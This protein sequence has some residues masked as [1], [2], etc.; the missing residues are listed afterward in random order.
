VL[1]RDGKPGFAEV[2][3]SGW[4]PPAGRS[5]ALGGTGKGVAR[6]KG[7]KGGAAPAKRGAAP[8]KS[9]AGA[10]KLSKQRELLAKRFAEMQYDLGGIAYEM[11]IRDKFRT[12]VLKDR[13]AKLRELD[14]QL[15]Q[16]DG[17][18]RLGATGVAGSCPNCDALQAKGAKFCWQCGFNL[19]AKRPAKPKTTTSSAK[20]AARKPRAGKKAG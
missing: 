16:V 7:A 14:A 1:G 10:R 17:M 2:F 8:A 4:A 3:R 15:T 18:L 12:Q 19:K 13:A 6:V 9:G 11:A 20:T 5:R